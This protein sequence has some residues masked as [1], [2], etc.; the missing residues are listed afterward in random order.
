MGVLGLSEKSGPDQCRGTFTG[1][2]GTLGNLGMN[3]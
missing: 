1:H 2:Y 3:P